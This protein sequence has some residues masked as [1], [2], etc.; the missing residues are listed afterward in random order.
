LSADLV[1]ELRHELRT[2]IN[3]IIGYSEMLEE[4]AADEHWS[5]L[6][7]D[8]EKV[9]ASGKALLAI[10][11]EWLTADKFESGK[12]KP[13]TVCRELRTPLDC[14]IGYSQLLQEQA[15]ESGRDA[16][17]PDLHTIE[18]AAT[19]LLEL[20]GTLVNI[21]T[22]STPAPEALVEAGRSVPPPVAST[23]A[24][25]SVAGARLL[26]V[27]D[28]EL[29]RDMLSR[30]LERLGYTVDLACDGVEA[31][32]LIRREPFELIL[33]D[34]M[35]PVMDGLEVLGILKADE[36]L[37]HLPV[38]VLSAVDDLS[39]VVRSLEMGAEDFLPKPFEP[40]VLRARIEAALE[41]KRLRDREVL[42]LREIEQKER[43]ADELL[44]VIL[45]AAIVQELKTTNT[46]QPRLRDGVAVMFVDIVGFTPYCDGRAPGEV[47]A[48]LQWL[49]ERYEDLAARHQLQKL[50]T[51]GD[52]F[53]AAAGLLEPLE[54]PI[55]NCVQCGLDMIATAEAAPAGWQVRVGLDVGPVVAGLMGRRQYLFDVWGDTVNTAARMQSIGEPGTITLSEPAWRLIQ[56]VAT[57]ES[58]GR[59]PVKGKGSLE[60]FRFKSINELVGLSR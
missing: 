53:M 51:I 7:P 39:H 55:L 30:R 21:A 42:Y 8:L 54:N 43:R 3:H 26:V 47:V 48:N 32:E 50:K 25:A 59:V 41:K 46:V 49:V 57:A 4:V 24:S 36:Q 37:R 9:R 16:I 40:A 11:S 10:V 28:N 58:R 12:F 34:I 31:L 20:S 18:G 6:Q 15:E 2:P 45:P 33:L 23:W 14:V 22:L 60:V 35:M 29:N 17:L 1:R 27:D 19:H 56:H 38:V 52:C 13:E 5:D 44:H